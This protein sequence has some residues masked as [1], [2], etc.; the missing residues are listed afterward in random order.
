MPFKQVGEYE[1]VVEIDGDDA[2]GDQVLEYLIHHGLEGSRAIC[3][4]KVHD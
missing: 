1:N 3:E 2:F 4:A